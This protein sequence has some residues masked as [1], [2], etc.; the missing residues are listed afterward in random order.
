MSI[1]SFRYF[2]KGIE[3]RGESTDP[4]DNVSGSIFYN[5]TDE[6]L[7]TYIQAAVREVVTA[8]QAQTLTNKTIDASSNTVSNIATSMLASGVLNTSTSLASASNLQVPSA[9][10]VK[11]YVDAGLLLQNDASEISY[12]PTG[13][14][15]S[16]NVQTAVAEV[17][18]DIDSHAAATIAHGATGAVVGTT[19]IQTLTNKTLTSPVINT[20]TGIVKGDVGLGNV[21]NTSDA[22][23]NAATATLTNKTIVASANTISAIA[24]ANIDAS[25]AIARTKIA[26]GTNNALVNN[27]PSGVLSESTDVT[28]GTNSFTLANTKH[29]EIQAAT[30]STTTGAAASLTAFTGGAIRLTN[31]SLVS[32]ANIPAGANGQELVIF[33]RTGAGISVVDS[34]ATSGTAANRI[35]TGTSANISFAKDAAL[36]LSYDS[37]SAR[38]QVIGGTGGG[39]SSDLPLDTLAQQTFESATLTDFTQTG[40]TLATASNVLIKN[41]KVAQLVSNASVTQSFKQVIAVDNEFKGKNLTL[42]LYTRSSATQGNVTILVYNETAGANLAASQPITLGS[43]TISATTAI[44]T[45]ISALSV[46]DVNKLKIGQTITGSGIVSGTTI[47]AINTTA[48]TATLSTAATAA[49]TVTLRISDL[50]QKQSFSFDV[51]TNCASLSYTISTLAEAGS[52]ESYFDDI[53][54]KMTATALSSTSVTVPLNNNFSGVVVSGITI[55]A[56]TT[57]PTKGTIVTDRVVTSRFE[58][59]LIADYQFEQSAGG[60]NGSGDVLF[61]LPSGLSFDSSLVSFS[62]NATVNSITNAKTVVGYGQFSNNGSAYN[63]GVLI[64]YDSTRFRVFAAAG[65]TPVFMNGATS[66]SFG[67][68]LGFGFH[69]DAPIAGWATNTTTSTTIPL[70]TAQLVQTHDSAFRIDNGGVS[71][72]TGST[73]TGVRRFTNIR[74]NIGTAVQFLDDAINGSR[75]VIQ[76]AGV[77]AMSFTESATTSAYMSITKNCTTLTTIPYNIASSESLAVGLCTAGG[78]SSISASAY[79]NIGDIIRAQVTASSVTTSTQVSSFE[80]TKQGSLKQLNPS[81]DSKIVIPTHQLRFEGASARGSTDTAI[82]KFDTQAITQGDGFSVVNT[83]ANGTVVTVNKAGKLTIDTTILTGT[84]IFAI[85]L[86]EINLA[87]FTDTAGITLAKYNAT[88]GTTTSLSKTID[89]KIN[90]KV[91]IASSGNPT[92]YVG[93]S[94]SLS[95]TENSIPA[96]FSNVLP[97]WS[98]SDSSV[99]LDTFNAYG[100]T[101]TVIPRFSNL[102]ENLGSDV[103]YTD[104][105]TLGASF[106]AITAGI[107]TIM[108]QHGYNSTTAQT[109]FGLSKNSTQLTTSITSITNS[110]VLALRNDIDSVGSTGAKVDSVTWSG[111]LAVGDVVRPHTDGATVSTASALKFTISK[112]GK[113]NLTA[114]D[115]TPF[116]NMKT[117]D[118]EAIEALTATST[119]GST[120]TGVPVLNI[121]RNTNL[122]VIQ[123]VSDAVSGT[124]FVAL[125]DCEIKIH[126]SNNSTTTS[127]SIYI[128][129]NATILTATTPDGILAISG[130]ATG[131]LFNVGASV[132]LK[133]GDVIRVQRATTGI[134]NF[135]QVTITA[136][137]DNNATAAP[138]QQVS[139]DT[140]SFNFKATAIDPSVDAIGTFNTF[141][142]GAGNASTISATAP[143]QTTSSM[144][145]NGIQVFTAAYGATTTS[146][147]PARVDIFIGKGLKSKQVD[148]YGALAKTLPIFI[149]SVVGSTVRQ[150]L[151]TVYNETTGILS[152]DARYSTSNVTAA[153]FKG[154]HTTVDT[155]YTSGYFVFNASKSPSL[156]T[157]PNLTQRIAYLTDVKSS[158]TAG[159]S[160]VATTWTNRDLNTTVDPTGIIKS[161]ATNQFILDAG[162]YEINTRQPLCSS[163]SGAVAGG[164]L[165]NITD[166]ITVDSQQDYMDT[167]NGTNVWVETATVFT[168]TSTKTF[169]VQYYTGNAAT[170]Y[171]LGQNSPATPEANIFTR[172]KINKIK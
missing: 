69:L 79:L 107:Y 93:N 135:S 27:S 49:A 63:N 12:A 41:A 8:N 106:T 32:L 139:S 155:S 117:T 141:A 90:D 103:T 82:V 159:G 6:R 29:L 166:G 165:R 131:E 99:R 136:T 156:V 128:T 14:I 7:R 5:S 87:A 26:S 81:S 52:P 127:S 67:A 50:P 113:P 36:I 169:A 94:F 121:T 158:G 134:V 122:G 161:L 100:S 83:A 115:V 9:L 88:A 68:V 80:I 59:R 146:A 76:E 60:T 40:L 22:T 72:G 168:I 96:N 73:A 95:L 147:S 133:S 137:A 124:K 145:V 148:G 21:D 20:P 35:F 37:T 150:G 153:E 126:A 149:D 77:Y 61:T 30:D 44:G 15:S 1:K 56:V 167:T 125:K 17:S 24:N 58:N 92:S 25:A 118:T 132:A 45:T 70:T 54:I 114:V 39:G 31:A 160:S 109:I 140:M 47:T 13:T 42:N 164:R 89:V 151:N 16:T 138:T 130:G 3:L 51:P 101:N 48:L 129:R 33:N 57:A 85:T 144:N 2:L 142:Y 86:N 43:Q 162:T 34:S 46:A 65:G 66:S 28:L 53:A 108:Y 64:A 152:L 11:S 116:V 112:V 105:A 10:A 104:S 171:G 19:N 154:A 18:G 4:T 38:W 120:N 84:G 23:K 98:Q 71:A 75:W 123:V 74:E 55:G 172:V 111:Y 102:V 110:D 62:T 170:T 163:A 143:T 78:E 157:I 97:Q 119:F 91:R